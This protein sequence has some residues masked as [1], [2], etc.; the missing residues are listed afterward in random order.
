MTHKLFKNFCLI[1]LIA[2]VHCSYAQDTL[3]NKSPNRLFVSA[4]FTPSFFYLEPGMQIQYYLKD[5]SYLEL[6]YGFSLCTF[7]AFNEGFMTFEK[8]NGWEGYGSII[9]F[10]HNHTRND[11]RIRDYRITY[12]DLFFPAYEF[13]D[14]STGLDLTPWYHQSERR[15]VLVLNYII[16]KEI[17]QKRNFSIEYTT[18]IGLAVSKS[19]LT[20]YYWYAG[21]DATPKPMYPGEENVTKYL[22]RPS[23]GF[24]FTFYFIAYHKTFKP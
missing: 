11:D 7:N 5:D 4:Y 24:G 22:P 6:K 9:R 2:D 23:I 1:F 10:A 8:E 16:G 12:K 15:R 18:I 21:N 20:R 17:Y 13:A 19:D 3:I 14:G